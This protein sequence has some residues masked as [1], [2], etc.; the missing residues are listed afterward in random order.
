[1]ETGDTSQGYMS[2]LLRLWQV[3]VAGEAVWRA[4]LESP[5]TPERRAFANLDDLF[6]FLTEETTMKRGTTRDDRANYS[7]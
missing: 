4:S 1:M 2:Y 7:A 3:T 5:V 6:A